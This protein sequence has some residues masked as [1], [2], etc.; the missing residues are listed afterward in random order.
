MA[1]AARVILVSTI[2]DAK[3][4]VISYN[5]I[6]Y[7]AGKVDKL[8]VNADKIAALK[9]VKIE[10][11]EVVESPKGG[12]VLK[13][14][15]GVI[16]RY[17]VF[18]AS[19]SGLVQV[20]HS[21]VVVSRLIDGFILSDGNGNIA[22]L[23]T[24]DAVGY[25]KLQGIANGKL[26]S[27][28]GK[29]TVSSIKGNYVEENDRVVPVTAKKVESK[30]QYTDNFYKMIEKAF[31]KP[32][33][34][35]IKY[36]IEVKGKGSPTGF[37][38]VLQMYPNQGIAVAGLLVISDDAENGVKDAKLIKLMSIIVEDK[39]IEAIINKAAAGVKFDTIWDCPKTF[40]YKEDP[41]KEKKYE[42]TEARI[43]NYIANYEKGKK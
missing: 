42:I 41:A 1:K 20:S 29:E 8:S 2:R 18:M 22:K 24:N 25:F 43:L 11:A 5:F 17:P 28:D 33:A 39:A 9:K 36:L 3:S 34:A 15:N 19:P 31:G 14:T 35:I 32:K 30:T 6:S 21:L 27:Q 4:K 38:S 7:N 10:N 37:A 26:V 12:C 40:G 23:T 16:D 13:G